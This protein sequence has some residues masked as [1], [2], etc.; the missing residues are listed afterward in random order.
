MLSMVSCLSSRRNLTFSVTVACLALVNVGIA[1]D[2]N[3]A[4]STPASISI[5]PEPT[6][7]SLLEGIEIVESP[8]PTVEG[9]TFVEPLNPTGPQRGR[10]L[11]APLTWCGSPDPAIDFASEYSSLN[12]APL[13]TEIDA[14][15]TRIVDDPSSPFE[16]ELADSYNVSLDGLEY[17]FILRNDLKFSDGSP[18]TSGDFK[19]S[20]ER[21]LKKS[22]AGSRARDVFGLIEGADVE[23]WMRVKI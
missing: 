2:A 20:W 7:S 5:D 9:E 3:D 19:W 1:C 6:V 21:S 13:V 22:E 17:E 14:G 16:L 11:A 4:T 8:P 23:R 12:G 15:L 18:L 10:V